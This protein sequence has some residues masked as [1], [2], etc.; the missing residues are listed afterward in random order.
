MLDLLQLAEEILP[1]I[2]FIWNRQCIL[3]FSRSFIEYKDVQM[4]NLNNDTYVRCKITMKTFTEKKK[5]IFHLLCFNPS[6]AEPLWRFDDYP[7]S[8]YLCQL[9]QILDI[10]RL[11]LW[12]GIQFAFKSKVKS[13][14]EI[15]YGSAP[16]SVIFLAQRKAPFFP[17]HHGFRIQHTMQRKG[18]I[19]K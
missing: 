16:V 9:S 12:S 17:C 1:S 13:K 15:R 14:L 19:L 2:L 18:H 5:A 11:N 10:S 4:L 6:R 7:D 3:L 8:P